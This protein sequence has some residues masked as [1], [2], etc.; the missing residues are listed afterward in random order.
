MRRAEPESC[1]PSCRSIRDRFCPTLPIRSPLPSPSHPPTTPHAMSDT[2]ETT[3]ATASVPVI[4]GN[5]APSAAP[6]TNKRAA[7]GEPEEV[8]EDK[9]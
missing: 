6:E 5:D 3:P 2:A 9:K 1:S 4:G 8:P 7:E